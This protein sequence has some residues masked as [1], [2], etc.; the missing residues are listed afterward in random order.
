MHDEAER[1]LSLFE[2]YDGA[3][4]THGDMVRNPEKNEKL[5]IKMSARTV[6]E[7]VTVELWEEHL[8]GERYLGIIPTR[9]DNTCVWGCI[10]VDRYDLD[11]GAIVRQLR[12]AHLPLIVCRTKSGG[13]HIYMFMAEPVPAAEI[14]A[15]LRDLSAL[16]GFGGSEIFPKQT[17]VLT[18]S[19]DLGN[20]LNMPYHHGDQTNRYCVNEQGRGLTLRQFLAKAEAARLT[21]DE[22]I[23]LR[24]ANEADDEFRDGPPCLQHLTSIGFPEGTRNNGLFGVGTFLKKKH[25][26]KW[27]LLLEQV[28]ARY[29]TP[30]LP[31]AEVQ[32]I[33]K[34][35]RSK[36]YK[37]KCSDMPLASHCNAGLCR[38]RKH[39]VGTKGTVPVM[40]SLAVLDTDEPVWFLDVGGE[41]IE[42]T[43]D[44]LQ[45]PARFQKRCME[46]VNIIVPIMKKETWDQILQGL[47]DNLTKI[48]APAEASLSGQFF[49]HIETF[50]TDRQQ[51]QTMEEIILGKAWHDDAVG[52]V[53]FRLR[54]IQEYLE[55]VKFRGM[56]RTQMTSKIR[57][58]RGGQHFFNVKG[59][60]V[61]VFWLPDDLFSIQ[62]EEHDLPAIK[63]EV[64]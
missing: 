58:M 31:S 30:P 28:N 61:N 49:E 45:V 37:Y 26:D 5:E 23:A 25:P 15:K 64:L 62:S 51:A 44:E 40:G 18:D 35:L 55:K 33:I 21:P 6:R 11:H 27:E 10:D 48:E 57:D 38:T 9:R 24:A 2:G 46:S 16:L 36:D 22:M 63:E 4:G 29:F 13:A 50:C 39:G 42:L 56:T 53:Y 7:P 32:Q 12:E 54:D 47:F 3:H 41:R 1:M 17:K 34:S 20:W 8:L 59:R 60:G 14:Q 19:G 52:R 43:T